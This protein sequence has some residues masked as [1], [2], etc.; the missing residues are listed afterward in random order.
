M[1]RREVAVFACACH[2]FRSAISQ[3]R[4]LRRGVGERARST[5]Y[6]ISDLC[7]NS[8]IF[9]FRRDNVTCY[10]LQLK[11][12]REEKELEELNCEHALDYPHA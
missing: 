7:R 11:S 6:V 12:L 9:V 5:K 10:R 2:C 3:A 1:V 8:R 4:A